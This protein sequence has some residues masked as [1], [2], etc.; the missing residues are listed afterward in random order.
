MSTENIVWSIPENTSL[1]QPTKFTFAIPDMPMLKYFCQTV[2]IPSVSTTE[3]PVPTPFNTTYR[4]G[5]SLAYDPLTIT[6]IIDED[7]RVYEE[8]LKWLVSLTEPQDFDQYP[9]KYLKDQT[10]LYKDAV[11]TVNT[12]A[13]N[14]NFR[15][16]F[17]D[18]HPTTMGAIPFDTKVNADSP[19]TVDITWRFDYFEI[20]RFD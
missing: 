12:N 5:H 19:M 10:P 13:N 4:H 16:I 15:L 18:C 1:L 2:S 6:A 3:I 9:R 14:P 20:E 7:F 11:L 8:T 17:K